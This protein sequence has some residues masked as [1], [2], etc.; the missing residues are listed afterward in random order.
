MCT[1][2]GRFTPSSNIVNIGSESKRIAGNHVAVYPERL[3]NYFIQGSTDKGDLVLDPFIGTGTT[4]VVAN[5]LGREYI[6]FDTNKEYVKFAIER[7]RKGP[8]ISELVKDAKQ[9]SIED[10]TD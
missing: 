3:V 8:Y 10:F 7:V 9:S 5:A 4:A 2:R 6:G 1:Q